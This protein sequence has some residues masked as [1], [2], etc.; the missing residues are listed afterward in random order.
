MAK[1]KTEPF[2]LTTTNAIKLTVEEVYKWDRNVH[3]QKVPKTTYE[4]NT[5][6]YAS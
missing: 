3:P 5:I 4:P 2:N 1:T 6:V